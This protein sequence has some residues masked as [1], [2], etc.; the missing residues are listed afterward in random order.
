MMRFLGGG[1]EIFLPE[2]LDCI[3]D[4]YSLSDTCDSHFFES[5]LIQIKQDIA[6]DVIVLESGCKMG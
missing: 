4:S 2:D 5:R 6:F 3:K 1:L